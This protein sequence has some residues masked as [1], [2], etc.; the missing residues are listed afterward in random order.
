M[1]ILRQT[2]IADGFGGL[3]IQGAGKLCV[4]VQIFPGVRH[5]VVNVSGSRDMLGDIC[6]V[7]RNLGRDNSL[8]YI[9]HVGKGQMLR[10][11]HIAEEGRTVHGRH[12]SADGAGNMIVA[13]SDIRHQGAQHIEGRAHAEGFLHFHVGGN[14]IQR[15]MAGAFHHHLHVV[16]PGP[17]G[18]LAQ[19]HQLLNLA[20]I[21]G[22]R[23]TAGPAGVSQGN[24][25]IVLL[26]DIQNFV[27]VFIE[28]ILLAGHTHPGKHQASAPADNVHFPLML[29][30]LVDGLSGNAA[31]ESHKIHPILC[32]EPYHV[33]EILRRQRGQIP[34]IVDHTVINR[35]RSDHHR[36]FAGKLLPEGLGV[37][38]AGEIHDGL[39]S[40]LHG[41][42]HLLHLHIVILAIP[43]NAQIYINLGPQHTSHTFRIQAGMLFVGTDRHLSAG[44]QF[45]QGF[46]VHVLFLRHARHLRRQNSF[47]CG[48]HLC[49]IRHHFFLLHTHP[50]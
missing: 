37:S 41:A 15:H 28:R 21:G 50:P 8:F 4:P 31:V 43:G 17:F 22:I 27:K 19:P 30:D 46:G 1:V 25:H 23:Q 35:H 47:S 45:H 20:D 6:R 29:A 49:G 7:S 32:V 34:L 18:Q 9:L 42:H 14:L 38:M 11:G 24:S 13:R 12:G 39:R 33:D 44:H 40:Q 2:V 3:G 16:I 10:R 26:A 5:F 48:V 36:T